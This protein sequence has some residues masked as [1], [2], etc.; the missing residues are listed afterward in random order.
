MILAFGILIFSSIAGAS[1]DKPVPADVWL[2]AVPGVAL[3]VNHVDA[4]DIYYIRATITDL[5]SGKVLSTPS[6]TTYAG[7]PATVRVG[8]SGMDGMMSINFTVTVASTG[9][10]AA[11]TSE[12][13]N[14]DAVVSSQSATLAVSR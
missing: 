3:N 2:N 12:V 10:V 13:R 11:F 14:N 9:D 8:G 4:S 6:L 7:N 1:A 5:R